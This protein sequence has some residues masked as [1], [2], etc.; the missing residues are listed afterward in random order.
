MAEQ[1]GNL[2]FGIIKPDAVRAGKTG[3][4]LQRVLDAGFKFRALKL[5]HLTKP[6]AEG[7][8]EVH[9]ERPFFGELTVF[10]SSGPCVV[11]ALEKENAVKAW[12]DLMG[13]TDPAKADEGTLRKEF[14]NSIGENA[15]HG[16]DSEENA[17]I[18]LAYFFS[19]LEFV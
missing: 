3:A 19:R 10:M 7:F 16:S 1:T 13:A 9:R 8:Y 18:E 6:E 4:V 11:M 2:T 15:V 14:A 5:I 17:R 12:R